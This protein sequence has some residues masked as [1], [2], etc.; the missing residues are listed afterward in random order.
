MVMAAIAVAVA[1]AAQAQ[2]ARAFMA[3]TRDRE[4]ALMSEPGAI[5]FLLFPLPCHW[6]KANSD[7]PMDLRSSRW[8]QQTNS[9]YGRSLR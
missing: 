3:G 9:S 7:R 4:R 8:R 6:P 5:A 2:S 1:S